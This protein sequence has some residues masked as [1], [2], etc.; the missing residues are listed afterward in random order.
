MSFNTLFAVVFTLSFVITTNAQMI[1]QSGFAGF[2]AA[3]ENVAYTGSRETI[4]AVTVMNSQRYES[5]S[6]P[7][8]T[9]FLIHSPLKKSKIGI[10]LS[11]SQTKQWMLTNQRVG[12]LGSYR[13]D[14]NSTSNLR[15]GLNIGLSYSTFG[16]VNIRTILPDNV[17]HSYGH[18]GG[19]MG[20]GLL[21]T[22][23]RAKYGMSIPNMISPE[24]QVFDNEISAPNYFLII[25]ASNVFPVGESAIQLDSR[26]VTGW[27]NSYTRLIL[28]PA[29]VFENKSWLGL[30]VKNLQWFGVQAGLH[31]AKHFDIGYSYEVLNNALSGISQELLLRFEL[32]RDKNITPFLF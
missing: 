29:F 8:V 22:R 15:F 28:S 9:T 11:Y 30:Q 12:L 23:K 17:W 27:G 10:G 21:Y 3:H 6:A 20:A 5:V 19:L 14:L 13:V 31:F 4:S 24:N 2:N 32:N 7:R 1:T 18:I 25:N 26:L 16:G